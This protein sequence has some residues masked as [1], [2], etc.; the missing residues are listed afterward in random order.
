[1]KFQ[2]NVVE[3]S[4]VGWQTILDSDDEDVSL[5]H[6][7]HWGDKGWELVTIVPKMENGTTTGYGIVFKKPIHD[8]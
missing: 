4:L 5:Q 8:E 3:V 7:N 6:L 1:M 2:Y